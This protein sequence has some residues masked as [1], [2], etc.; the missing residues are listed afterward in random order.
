VSYLPVNILKTSIISPLKRLYLNV[1][2]FNCTS[3]SL[4]VKCLTVKT[5]VGVV[6]LALQLNRRSMVYFIFY[7]C[8]SRASCVFWCVYYVYMG[9]V[10]EIIL[11]MMMITCPRS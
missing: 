4:Y 7:L 11:M 8:S 3:L 9:Q 10:P 2:N 1:G 6:A 5:N